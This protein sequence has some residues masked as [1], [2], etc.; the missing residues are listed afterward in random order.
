[1]AQWLTNLTRNHEVVGSRSLALRSGL[2]IWHCHELW[3]RSQTRLGFRVAVAVAGIGQQLQLIRPLAWEPPQVT[4]VALEK[5][6]NKQTNKKFR[7]QP[8]SGGSKHLC[9]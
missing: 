2:R 1:M 6:K 3:C 7:A 9:Q 5:S 4:G 8:Q